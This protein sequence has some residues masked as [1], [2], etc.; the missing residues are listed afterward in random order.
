MI[1]IL[2]FRYAKHLVGPTF[3]THML[4]L[5]LF[6]SHYGIYFT[7]IN[8]RIINLSRSKKLN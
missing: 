5:A 4:E 2:I 1:K 3:I 8:L 6:Y 7:R